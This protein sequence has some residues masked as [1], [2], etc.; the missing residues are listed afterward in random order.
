[1]QVSIV[2]L[3]HNL[4]INLGQL[5]V[6]LSAVLAQER[7]HW[8]EFEEYRLLVDLKVCLWFP[9]IV[10]L[11]DEVIASSRYHLELKLLHLRLDFLKCLAV[12]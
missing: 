4:C 10:K 7:D 9:Q 2:D 11:G 5:A 1:M 12:S 8:L 6:C 3:I